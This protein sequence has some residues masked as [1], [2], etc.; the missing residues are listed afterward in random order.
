MRCLALCT[1]ITKGQSEARWAGEGLIAAHQPPAESTFWICSMFV[2]LLRGESLRVSARVTLSQ[3]AR[4]PFLSLKR[5]WQVPPPLTNNGGWF[6]WLQFWGPRGNYTTE[7]IQS[8]VGVAGGKKTKNKTIKKTP[9]GLHHDASSV[10]IELLQVGQPESHCWQ[11]VFIVVVFFVF[12][13]WSACAFLF[14]YTRHPASYTVEIGSKLHQVSGKIRF[15]WDNKI[16]VINRKF[17]HG[18]VCWE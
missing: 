2:G 10:L 3:L 16:K 14:I 1:K 4:S 5:S 17:K 6:V 9:P 12:L 15:S 11:D 13:M 18:G 8:V 7:L